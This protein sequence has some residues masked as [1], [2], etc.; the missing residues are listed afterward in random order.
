MSEKEVARFVPLLKNLTKRVYDVPV[1][2]I[3]AVEGVA[4]GKCFVSG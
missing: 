2:V 3:A 1:P 4:L